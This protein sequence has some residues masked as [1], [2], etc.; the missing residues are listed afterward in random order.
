MTD[1]RPVAVAGATIGLIALL[2]FGLWG[3]V[4]TLYSGP[5]WAVFLNGM[6]TGAVALFLYLLWK[7]AAARMAK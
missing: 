3:L 4:T 7:E 5:R 1:R 2:L 6:A